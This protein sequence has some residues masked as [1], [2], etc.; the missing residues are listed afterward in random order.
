MSPRVLSEKKKRTA[1]GRAC[2]ASYRMV[3]DGRVKS[4]AF[5]PDRPTVAQYIL[6]TL[7]RVITYGAVKAGPDWAVANMGTPS[8][9]EQVRV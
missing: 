6:R 8:C 5:P 7:R 1:R 9:T 2:A 3:S 4:M